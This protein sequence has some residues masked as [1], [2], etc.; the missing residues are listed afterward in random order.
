MAIPLHNKAM[1]TG[2]DRILIVAGLFSVCALLS[3]LGGGLLGLLCFVPAV[4]VMEASAGKTE[5]SDTI[6]Q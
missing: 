2:S 3:S 5:Q 1:G 4:I 6:E